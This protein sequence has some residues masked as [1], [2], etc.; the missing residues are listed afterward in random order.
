MSNQSLWYDDQ[1]QYWDIIRDFDAYE[2]RTVDGRY[3]C[4]LSENHKYY[5]TRKLLWE[6]H[7][8]EEMLEWIN[9]LTAEHWVCIYGSPD[10]SCWGADMVL[11]KDIPD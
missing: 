5:P 6:E 11:K 9:K 2:R 8:F 7:V 1:G 3:Y 4:Y 10:K